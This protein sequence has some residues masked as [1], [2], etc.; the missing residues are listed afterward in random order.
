M[1]ARVKEVMY[2]GLMKLVVLDPF[3]AGSI[4][5]LLLPHFLNFYSEVLT[6]ISFF[7][8]CFEC[9]FIFKIICLWI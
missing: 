3:I 4:F 2:Y 8:L 7:F 1:Q 9:I 5:D 6:F